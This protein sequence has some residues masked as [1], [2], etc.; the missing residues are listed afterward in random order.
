MADAEI[1]APDGDAVF[2]AVEGTRQPV[3]TCLIIDGGDALVKYITIAH[4]GEVVD[5][6]EA[7]TLS[8]TVLTLDGDVDVVTLLRLQVWVLKA[9]CEEAEK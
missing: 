6:I 2:V 4:K 7:S 5:T 9:F 3:I 8:D 1:D